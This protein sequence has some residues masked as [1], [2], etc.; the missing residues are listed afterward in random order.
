MVLSL[1][2]YLGLI[3]FLTILIAVIT[4]ALT[5]KGKVKMIWHKLF[6]I[7][8]FLIALVHGFLVMRNFF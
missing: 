5:L 8:A 2:I 6:G 4:G 3:G 7:L 1:N